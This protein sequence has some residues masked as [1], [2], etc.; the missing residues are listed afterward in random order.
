MKNLFSTFY[1]LLDYFFLLILYPLEEK[2]SPYHHYMFYLIYTRCRVPRVSD[3]HFFHLFNLVHVRE[4][5]NQ[6]VNI[7]LSDISQEQINSN[8]VQSTKIK[9]IVFSRI[10]I[11]KQIRIYLQMSFYMAL[12]KMMACVPSYTTQLSFI[13]N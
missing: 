7:N 3:L 10:C 8:Y 1:T 2:V 5:G 11:M 9:I 6:Y 4:G 13:Y 12:H